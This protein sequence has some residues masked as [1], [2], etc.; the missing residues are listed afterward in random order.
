MAISE[1][2]TLKEVKEGI[3]L[4]TAD[5]DELLPKIING[6]IRQ[7]DIYNNPCTE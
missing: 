3:E 7:N 6:I 1:L 2:L 4:K 5:F